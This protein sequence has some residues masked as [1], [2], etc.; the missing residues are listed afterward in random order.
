[1]LIGAGASMEAGLPSWEELVDRLLGRL[2]VERGLIDAADADALAAWKAEARRDGFLGAAAV[3]D[4][5]AGDDRDGW[6]RDELFAES[7][8]PQSF[9]P[10]P[11]S[12]QVPL[13]QRV[14]E[15]DLRIMTTNYDDLIEQ[16]FRDEGRVEPVALATGD[17]H[18][19]AGQVPVLHLHG[20]LGRDDADPGELV[21]SEADYQ[22]MQRGGAWQEDAV[23][24]AL[25]ES[26][27]IFVGTSLL[28]PNLIRYL[29]GA[30]S[31]WRFIRATPLV[32]DSERHG[33]IPVG[34][35]TT[36]SMLGRDDSRLAAMDHDVEA[37]FNGVLRDGVLRLL[38]GPFAS[39]A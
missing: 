27:V 7:G 1:M 23:R 34:C 26:T 22:R 38:N 36:A 4:A 37:K 32:L 10:G 2:A 17:H 11:I 13:L 8:E 16:A 35:L 18:V 19:A 29:H 20:Y 3:V 33:R 5:L 6:I 12:R 24:A 15:R 31:R 9:F 30:T 39:G 28:D 14:F 25:R 21:L